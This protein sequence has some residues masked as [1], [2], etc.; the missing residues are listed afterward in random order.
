MDLSDDTV[1]RLRERL[2]RLYGADSERCLRGIL[3]KVQEYDFSDLDSTRERW[4][5]RDVVLITYG[6]QVQAD[7][8]HALAA[9]QEFLTATGLTDLLNTLHILPFF[10]YSSDDGF[11]VID[12]RAVDPGVGDWSDVSNLR[13]HVDLMF[14]LVLNHCSQHSDWF[15]KYL[16]GNERFARFF[17]EANPATD[18]S[19]VTRPR[20]LPL[21]TPFETKQGTRHIWTTFS[22]DQ[23]DL[24]FAEPEVLVEF[25]DILLFFVQQ[26]AR[27]IRLDA[28]AYL[29]KKIGTSC[30][31]LPETH[32]VVKLIRDILDAVAPHVSL[33]TETNVPHDE[34]VSY[35][36]KSDE[37]HMVYQFSLPPLLLDAFLNE[38]PTPLRE[39]LQQLEPPPA[40]TTF[41]NFT[42]SHDGV[43]VRP[44]EG[45]VDDVRLEE[46][47]NVVRQRNGL[48]STR[49][50]ADGSESPYELNISYV[51]ALGSDDFDPQ[52]HAKRFLASQ[53]VMLSL[54]GVPG[55]YFHSLVGTLNDLDGVEQ[56]GNSRRI[57]RR[58]FQLSELQSAISEPG[59]L[60][61]LIFVQYQEF[62]RVRISQAAF[63]PDG[64]CQIL[65]TDSKKILA[66]LRSSTDKAQHII[67]VVNFSREQQVFNLPSEHS[68]FDLL[69]GQE[70]MDGTVALDPF[71]V[72]WLECTA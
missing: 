35:F 70:K 13:Q 33:L 45:L 25:I 15:Q 37:A 18:L 59:S 69:S 56:S 20:S 49:R 55:I 52:T 51:D 1:N 24:N 11:S 9:Q 30:I 72:R 12:Y 54:P 36:G 23:V 57:N 67:V 19:Q 46:L 63:H 17:I 6:D 3:R 22:D 43:G 64:P 58:K 60:Q 61:E 65:D 66:F 27:I 2:N 71:Q 8:K 31:H 48:V 38:D 4:T 53:A 7:D 47:L 34:N 39:W 50:H 62:L 26:G 40:G 10:P 41:F 32:E 44:L 16:A 5:E 68:V 28:I 29:W 14:D 21:L 42:A